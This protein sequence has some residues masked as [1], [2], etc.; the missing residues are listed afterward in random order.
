V[1]K[2]IIEKNLF[3]KCARVLDRTF[4]TTTWRDNWNTKNTNPGFANIAESD[5]SLKE[6]AEAFTK[7]KGFKKVSF[8]QMGLKK[9]YG[10]M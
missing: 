3:Y 5:Y 9:Q 10:I 7:I 1:P 4:K 6:D 2:N 8:K